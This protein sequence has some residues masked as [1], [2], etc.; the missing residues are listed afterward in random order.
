MSQLG[1]LEIT[2]MNDQ[3]AFDKMVSHLRK[4]GCRATGSNTTGSNVCLLHAENGLMCAVG[5]LISKDDYDPI[6][7]YQPLSDLFSEV[8]V[9]KS[10]NFDMVWEMRNIHDSENTSDWELHFK[11]C[12]ENHGLEYKPPSEDNKT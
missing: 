4:Q 7:E 3:E 1:D 12:A 2:N 11:H 10:L 9:L 6:M 5:C 8:D